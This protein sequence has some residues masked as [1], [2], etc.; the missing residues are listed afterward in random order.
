MLS[1]IKNKSHTIFIRNLLFTVRTDIQTHEHLHTGH[2]GPIR[3]RVRPGEHGTQIRT[4]AACTNPYSG[5]ARSTLSFVPQPQSTCTRQHSGKIQRTAPHRTP[6]TSSTYW[7]GRDWSTRRICNGPDAT[8]LTGKMF[9]TTLNLIP[10]SRINYVR[11]N[12][13]RITSGISS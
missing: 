9:K 3:V 6:Y 8:A 2:H 5:H 11:H 4:L 13:A 7:M 12:T 1:R 10:H